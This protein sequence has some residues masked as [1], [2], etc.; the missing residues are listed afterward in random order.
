[1]NPEET[2][3]TVLRRHAATHQVNSGL[4]RTTITKA[5]LRRS[6]VIA[7][8]TGT[9]ASTMIAGVGVTDYLRDER[10]VPPSTEERAPN[11]VD[12]TD[13]GAPLVLLDEPGWSVTYI[14]QYGPDE[15][16]IGFTNGEREADLYWRPER[17]HDSYVQDRRAED[18]GEWD[19]EILGSEARFFK[20]QGADDFTALWVDGA[21]SLEL[22]ASARDIDEFR[23]LAAAL[24]TVDEETWLAAMP[25]NAV[26]PQERAATVEE[27]LEDVPVHP[28]I[29]VAELKSGDSVVDRYQLGAKVTGTVACAWI[30]QWLD[31]RS[32]GDLVA[33]REAEDAMASARE[34]SVLVEMKDQGGWTETVWYYADA[35]VEGREDR[36]NEELYANGKP[37]GFASGLG[38]ER[39]KD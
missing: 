5:R 14:D 19:A 33:A 9:I 13:A 26:L 11:N 37:L 22:R 34:W 10:P 16:E 24:T 1:M 29:D 28:D 35:V 6:L 17:L 18:E 21:L 4:P 15:G 12:R 39:Q 32:K 38:C 30:G 25:E 27:M 36:V 31:A 2:L 7:G 20:Y 23:A 8:V 3:R